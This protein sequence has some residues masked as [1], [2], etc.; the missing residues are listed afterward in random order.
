MELENNI[1]YY[2]FEAIKS[3]P[4]ISGKTLKIINAFYEANPNFKPTP[5]EGMTDI[6]GKDISI[7][8]DKLVFSLYGIGFYLYCYYFT[9][10]NNDNLKLIHY[11]Y[12]INHQ[13]T[14][15]GYTH[16]S[17]VLIS[18]ADIQQKKD[19]IQLLFNIGFKPNNKDFTLQHN[20]INASIGHYYS[21]SLLLS[22]FLPKDLIKVISGTI[23][24][25]L[26]I[27]NKLI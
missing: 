22:N 20:I 12:N 25:L 26:L 17:S 23:I 9:L 18:K 15:C 8:G 10:H 14:W 16:F 13:L 11:L 3:T 5:I 1:K 19:F 7:E 4:R 27:T 21:Y 24:D 6:V 2:F